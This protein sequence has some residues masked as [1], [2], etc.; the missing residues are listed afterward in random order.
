MFRPFHIACSLLRIP[1]LGISLFLVPIIA[2]VLI[3]V[4]QLVITGVLIRSAATTGALIDADSITRNEGARRESNPVRALLY[5]S[6]ARRPPI[7]VCRWN[8]SRVT[9][10]IEAPPTPECHPD[11]L[12]VALNV[13]D[14]A[15]FQVEHYVELFDGQVDRLHVCERCSPDV[16]ISI[17]EGETARTRVYSVY[18]LAVLLLSFVPKEGLRT[19]RQAE[20]HS[21]EQ[22]VGEVSMFMPESS[23]F[24]PLSMTNIAIPLTLNLV[25]LVIVTA[26]LALRAH[27]KVIHYFARNDVLLPLVAATG[28][29]DFYGALWL[30]TA[31]R[32]G[33]FLVASLPLVC[34]GLRDIVGKDFF[35]QLSGQASEL[36]VWGFALIPSIW[37]S[38]SIASL[39]D[40]RRRETF[41]SIAY[42][43]FPISLAFVG[44][45]AWM[46][47]FIV[48]SDAAATFRAI[49]LGVPILGISP[50]LIAPIT[51]P[52][53]GWLIVHGVLSALLLRRVTRVSSSW[54]GAHVEEI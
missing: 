6:G 35:R 28:K 1:H 49:L 3:V 27:R 23:R 8:S 38:T 26:W 16:V 31:T 43:Y 41:F 19:E 33:I 34:M 50:M 37:L 29:R 5:G 48:A 51:E 13:R 15:R 44:G 54:F 14:P 4:G 17:I 11:R 20:L 39:A 36:L 21:T 40:L 24:I 25:P 22:Y 47:S 10:E 9:P 46:G 45:I 52:I 7:H 30:L 18:G 32:V 12:D 42:R 53:E 2:S